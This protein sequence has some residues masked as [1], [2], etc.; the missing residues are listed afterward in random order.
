MKHCTLEQLTTAAAR[1][2]LFVCFISLQFYFNCKFSFYFFYAQLC[3]K[4][5]SRAL[6]EAW[7]LWLICLNTVCNN[8]SR[9]LH[10]KNLCNSCT[11]KLK[12][13]QVE[14]EAE[15]DPFRVLHL[16][17]LSSATRRGSERRRC[18]SHT[19]TR[20]N[21]FESFFVFG[22][23][24]LLFFLEKWVSRSVVQF[25]SLQL[26][27][28]GPNRSGK[29]FA[30]VCKCVTRQNTE[31]GFYLLFIYLFIYFPI[32]FTARVVV[33]YGCQLEFA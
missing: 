22:F 14:V 4:I 29:D 24:L 23:W 10:L 5:C 11:L 30:D 27:F 17:R 25:G 28:V 31:R 7:M 21:V 13:I 18:Q 9:L 26:E 33:S 3:I 12:L 1:I 6:I 15:R 8:F 16:Q 20:K 2:C 19:K 32:G